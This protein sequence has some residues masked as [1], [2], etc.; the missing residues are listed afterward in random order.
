MR[1]RAR[2]LAEMT[3]SKQTSDPAARGPKP[4]TLKKKRP[5]APARASGEEAGPEA[6]AAKLRKRRKRTEAGWRKLWR[7][8]WQK[9]V[10]K[11][12][13]F[14]RQFKASCQAVMDGMDL[15]PKRRK[16]GVSIQR[17]A[18]EVALEAASAFGWKTFQFAR[19]LS[20]HGPGAAGRKTLRGDMVSLAA[21]RR[22]L[23]HQPPSR[24]WLT[25][26]S[27]QH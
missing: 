24:G 21:A 17:A 7:E 9:R 15:P 10:M 14:R 26:F 1:E 4:K 16:T 22:L 6:G 2:L 3:R 18:V 25:A 13:P 20:E 12:G 27:T 11:Y 23:E 19:V 5:A 8:A